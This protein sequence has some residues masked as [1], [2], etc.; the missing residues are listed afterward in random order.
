MVRKKDR[1]KIMAAKTK[2]IEQQEDYLSKGKAI[3]RYKKEHPIK[4]FFKELFDA[5][6]GGLIKL[7]KDDIFH[8]L[9][10]IAGGIIGFWFI[11]I[12][13]D[14]NFS[15]SIAV[16]FGCLPMIILITVLN[17]RR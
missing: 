8:F 17:L 4:Y 5:L 1:Y 6:F 7:L 3:L 13:L 10:L 12:W 15:T 14:K 11:F 2:F 9:L 16:L